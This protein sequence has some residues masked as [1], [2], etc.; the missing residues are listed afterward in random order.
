MI[1]SLFFRAEQGIQGSR[2]M[3]DELPPS[4]YDTLVENEW[5]SASAINQEVHRGNADAIH[6][7]IAAAK[8]NVRTILPG[9]KE[10]NSNREA[11]NLDQK[12]EEEEHVKAEEMTLEQ[13]RKDGLFRSPD[14]R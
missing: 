14:E 12:P 9:E 6:K 8:E 3:D 13:A 1:V 2:I 10:L 11:P 7:D 4:P 5:K